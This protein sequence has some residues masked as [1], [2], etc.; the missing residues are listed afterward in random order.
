MRASARL[1]HAGEAIHTRGL[2]LHGVGREFKCSTSQR[3]TWGAGPVVPQ[4]VS[5]GRGRSPRGRGLRGWGSG[6]PG[7]WPFLLDFIFNIFIVEG[8][9]YVLLFPH[10]PPLPA[11]CC[12]LAHTPHASTGHASMY[13]RSLVNGL[14]PT[15]PRPPPRFRTLLTISFNTHQMGNKFKKN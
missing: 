5:P 6:D 4:A 13:T 15:L 8:I 11:P 10:R 3:G 14:P 2:C 12:P 1:S 7:V 9:P